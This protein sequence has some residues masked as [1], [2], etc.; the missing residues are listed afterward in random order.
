MWVG[1]WVRVA[2]NITECLYSDLELMIPS[3]SANS[4]QSFLSFKLLERVLSKASIKYCPGSL[5][6]A[7][8]NSSHMRSSRGIIFPSDPITFILL[9]MFDLFIIHFIDC[10]PYFICYSN[11]ITTI[12]W[13]DW[14][15]NRTSSCHEP[16]Q[17]LDKRV[18][19]QCIGYFNVNCPACKTCK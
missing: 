8:L 16:S 10:L 11:K 6:L 13:S 14:W 2:V 17:G 3:V 9:E 1:Y 15:S 18:N 5:N 19:A 12:I 4:V 7:L